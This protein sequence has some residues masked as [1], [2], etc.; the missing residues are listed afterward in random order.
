[1][2]KMNGRELVERIKIARPGIK[3]LFVSGYAEDAVLQQGIE[4]R[5]LAF[6]HKPFS[7]DTLA[8]KVREVLDAPESGG[9]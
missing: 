7:L 6:L 4:M 3:V 5:G 9:R 1:M 8:Q 2:P